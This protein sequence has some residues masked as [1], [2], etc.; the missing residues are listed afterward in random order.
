MADFKIS[1]W[2]LFV[3]KTIENGEEANLCTY[4]QQKLTRNY[5]DHLVLSFPEKLSVYLPVLQAP[6]V[7]CRHYICEFQC[8]RKTLLFH[9][10][11]SLRLCYLMSAP[12][13]VACAWAFFEEA[14]ICAVLNGRLLQIQNLPWGLMASQVEQCIPYGWKDHFQVVILTMTCVHRHLLL[15]CS[16]Y[17]GNVEKLNI[18]EQRC[19]YIK[20]LMKLLLW[21]SPSHRQYISDHTLY[22]TFT[23][24]Q[25]YTKNISVTKPSAQI[26]CIRWAAIW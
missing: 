21:Y 4:S 7:N 15:E 8:F 26:F 10:T 3:F 17:Q 1:P 24:C 19:T 18:A 11:H 5:P 12:L 14:C 16:V 13:S 9:I 25:K 23:Y 20:V 22:G 2:N 6:T